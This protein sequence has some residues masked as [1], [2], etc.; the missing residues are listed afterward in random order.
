MDR[1]AALAALVEPDPA[2][3][4]ALTRAAAGAPAG[5]GPAPP[6][7]AA[8]PG[9]PARPLLVH[10]ASVARRGPGSEAGRAALI[11][12]IAHIEFNAINLALDALCRFG[13]MPDAYYADWMKVALEESHHFSLLAAHLSTAY[14]HD[15]GDFPAHDGLWSMA[16]KTR[17][18]VLARMALVPRVLEARGLDVTPAMRQALAAHG[19]ADAAAIL[20]VILADEI[21][22]VAIGNRWFAHLCAERG[23]APDEA[24]ERLRTAYG[25]PRMRPPFNVA[26]RLAAGFTSAEL[27]AWAA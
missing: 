26:A 3:K 17:D 25:A 11:H 4:V 21:G 10:P 23:Q 9:R 27:E 5:D 8:A 2:A 12:A 18:D 22:H 15:Y 7:V 6:L 1:H 16:E 24:F 14:G 20:D 13:G 19:D